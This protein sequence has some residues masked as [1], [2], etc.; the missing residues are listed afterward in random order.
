MLPQAL[1]ETVLS[2]PHWPDRV[3]VALLRA[4]KVHPLFGANLM[5]V[6]V[7]SAPACQYK[8]K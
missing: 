1:I 6:K 2:L 8:N 3:W 4:D 5:C 7:P